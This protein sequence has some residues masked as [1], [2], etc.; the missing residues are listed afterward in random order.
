MQAVC[1]G[2]ESHLSSSFSFSEKKR[3]VQVSCVAMLIY[4]GIR[5]FMYVMAPF[6]SPALSLNY[7]NT[8]SNYLKLDTS[9]LVPIRNS[10]N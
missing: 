8:S 9:Q 7:G 3:V 2:F 1:R 6:L 4:E 5:V 10:W